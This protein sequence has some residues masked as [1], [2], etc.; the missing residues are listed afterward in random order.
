MRCESGLESG[1]DA[2]ID[3]GVRQIEVSNGRKDARELRMVGKIIGWDGKI[4]QSRKFINRACHLESTK[5]VAIIVE[6]GPEPQGLQVR[7]RKG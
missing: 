4:F 3:I 6:C 5:E 2:V 1:V 7:C